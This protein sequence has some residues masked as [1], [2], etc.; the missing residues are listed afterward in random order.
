MIA[1]RVT[2]AKLVEIAESG[3]ADKFDG[4]NF[5][6]ASFMSMNPC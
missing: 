6:L 2:L 3:P 1:F 4:L 5:E